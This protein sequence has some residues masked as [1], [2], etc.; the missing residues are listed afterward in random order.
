MLMAVVDEQCKE[1]LE[2]RLTRAG[3]LDYTEIPRTFGMGST[4]PRLGSRAFPGTSAVVFSLVEKEDVKAVREEV[5]ALCADH[6]APMHL[7]AWDVEDLATE[8]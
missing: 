6:D 5:G 2:V 8:G 1:E 3:V 7:V 4:G